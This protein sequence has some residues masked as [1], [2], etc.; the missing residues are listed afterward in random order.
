MYYR[1]LLLVCT[2]ALLSLQP[3][4]AIRCWF[5]CG[6]CAILNSTENAHHFLTVEIFAYALN[7]PWEQYLAVPDR[8]RISFRCVFRAHHRVRGAIALSFCLRWGSYVL[9][10]RIRYSCIYIARMSPTLSGSSALQHVKLG[11]ALEIRN[12]IIFNFYSGLPHM[13]IIT[14]NWDWTG[15]LELW[16]DMYQLLISGL[17][18]HTSRFWLRALETW[19]N[20][21][22]LVVSSSSSSVETAP[23]WRIKICSLQTAMGGESNE[24]KT[25]THFW[26]LLQML[27]SYQESTFILWLRKMKALANILPTVSHNSLLFSPK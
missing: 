3:H 23:C 25:Q 9:R 14:P 6:H 19:S 5:A 22:V 27:F 21:V 8:N 4:T 17:W 18:T 13:Y 1:L 12:G 24:N 16:I 11:D 10:G 20:T 2:C 15:I 7:N 26:K